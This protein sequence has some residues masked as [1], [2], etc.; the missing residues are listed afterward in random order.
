MNIGAAA[1]LDALVRAN[2]GHEQAL[3][4]G[5]ERLVD[6][7]EMEQGR[8]KVMHVDFFVH[9]PESE[10]IRSTVGHSAAKTAATASSMCSVTSFESPLSRESFHCDAFRD[11]EMITMLL[12]KRL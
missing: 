8:V 3:R 2:P 7:E 10:F 6:A 9:H 11:F 12:W 4:T 5:L 1:R